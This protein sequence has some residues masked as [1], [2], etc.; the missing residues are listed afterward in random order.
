M[1]REESIGIRIHANTFNQPSLEVGKK[2]K[3]GFD[4]KA[5]SRKWFAM[6]GVWTRDAGQLSKINLKKTREDD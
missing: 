6:V 3:F 4:S 1:T 2:Y 5:A